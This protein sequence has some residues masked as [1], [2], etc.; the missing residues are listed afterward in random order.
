MPQ[1]SF[2]DWHMALTDKSVPNYVG[3][4]MWSVKEAADYYRVSINWLYHQARKPNGP[5]VVRI[6]RLMRIPR[7][8]FMEWTKNGSAYEG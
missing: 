6:G 4:P 5:P 3:R 8:E 1:R 2:E 7:D